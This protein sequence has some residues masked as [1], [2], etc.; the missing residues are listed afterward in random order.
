[1]DEPIC[2]QEMDS[3]N[4]VLLPFYDPDTNIVYL[5]GKVSCF[6]A[7]SLR[8]WL[9]SFQRS[10]ASLCVCRATAAFGTLRSQ[11]RLPLFTTSTPSPPRSPRE[12]WDTCPNEAWMSTNAKSPGPA[13]FM[14]SFLF[15]ADCL[16]NVSN[17]LLSRFYKLHERKC[18]P[19]IMTVPRK[20]CLREPNLQM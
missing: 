13:R 2:V 12:A 8:L 10:N 15:S 16:E 14:D 1:M 5:C 3:S 7:A 11:M 18:E 4:G 9:N 17:H 19:I 20:V 6:L